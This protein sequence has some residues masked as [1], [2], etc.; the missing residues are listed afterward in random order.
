[1]QRAEYTGG[2]LP[3]DRIAILRRAQELA[4]QGLRRFSGDKYSYIVYGVLGRAFADLSGDC[5]ILDDAIRHIRNA[6]DEL[7][8]EMLVDRLRQFEEYRRQMGKH[9][10]PNPSSDEWR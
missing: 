10:E 3:E 8:D 9:P 7:L 4:L 1:V 5:T 2:I 6:A